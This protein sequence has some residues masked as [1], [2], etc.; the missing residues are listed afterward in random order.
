MSWRNSGLDAE[1]RH[2]YAAAVYFY[3]K[4]EKLP[5]EHWPTDTESLL[6]G[7]KRLDTHVIGQ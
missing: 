2:D 4:I 3:E 7:A 5:K 1:Q 6:A